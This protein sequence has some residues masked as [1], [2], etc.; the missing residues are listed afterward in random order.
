LKTPTGDVRPDAETSLG[1]ADWESAPRKLPYGR[2]L[3][4]AMKF[5]VR[6]GGIS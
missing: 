5:L 4:H 1:A 6:D 2:G 3:D